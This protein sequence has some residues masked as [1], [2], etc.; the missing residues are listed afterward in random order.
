MEIRALY[1]NNNTHRLNKY[2]CLN[3]AFLLIAKIMRYSACLIPKLKTQIEHPKYNRASQASLDPYGFVYINSYVKNE[4]LLCR[5]W[6]VRNEIQWKLLIICLLKESSRNNIDRNKSE[7]DSVTANG[8]EV[9]S[10]P[11]GCLQNVYGCMSDGLSTIGKRMR[12]NKAN[13]LKNS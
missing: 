1:I 10:F 2:F 7:S 11:F 6:W 5:I 12:I 13:V 8:W 3:Q 9:S 4:C